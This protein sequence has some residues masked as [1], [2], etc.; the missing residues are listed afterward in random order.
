MQREYLANLL[1]SYAPSDVT[2]IAA[3]S[4]IL[5]FIHN[6]SN[7][8]ERSSLDGHITASAWLLN[9]SKDQVLLLH[10]AKLNLWCQPG[11]HC[12]GDP[13][14]LNVAIKEAQEESGINEIVPLSTAIF[15]LDIHMIPAMNNVP[16]H[17]HYDI[18]FLLQVQTD[19]IAVGNCE[20]MAL[21][22]FGKEQELLP[23]KSESILRMFRKWCEL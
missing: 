15:D 1:R 2:E 19:A 5:D 16:K 8:F 18:R 23:T 20:S 17:Y 4:Q 9:K 14:V 12:D 3:T 7:C 6:N 11:G 22:W 13:D 21:R 10:H